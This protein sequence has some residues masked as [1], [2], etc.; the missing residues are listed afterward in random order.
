MK[1]IHTMKFLILAVLLGATFLAVGSTQPGHYDSN[2]EIFS[3]TTEDPYLLA[4]RA[5]VWGYPLVKAARIRMAHTNPDDPHVER[6][7]PSAAGPLNSLNHSRQLFG[8]EFRNGVGVNHDTLYSF[9]WYDLKDEAFVLEAPDFGDRYYTFSIYNADTTSADTIG[10][11]THGSQVPTVLIH[12][13]EYRGDIPEDML[14]VPV[15]TRYL[16]FAGRIL[17]DGSEA[18][19]RK[20]HALQDQIRIRSLS[21]YLQ[22][23]PP[24]DHVPDQIRV[25]ENV[26][27]FPDLEL[28]VQIGNLLRY[29]IPQEGEKE[30]LAS[31]ERIGLTSEGFDPASL[32]AGTREEIGRALA[33][34]MALI[35]KRSLDLGTSVNG[36]SINYQGSRFGDNYLLR[37]AVAKD[38]IYVAAP[39]EAIYPLA[40]VDARGEPLTGD[41][42]YR[43]LFDGDDLPPVDGF[44]SVT[45]YNDEGYLVDNPIDRHAVNERMPGLV[46]KANGDIEIRIQHGKPPGD[47]AVNWLPAPEGSFY[48]MM[49]LYIPH[50][51]ILDGTWVPPTIERLGGQ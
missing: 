49:R 41:A 44:W 6:P 32:D 17:A 42:S 18:D 2:E 21:R 47:E 30:L 46:K 31:F 23:K 7:Q 19:Y 13:P 20:V 48:L 4:L 16:N 27:Q 34:A 33:D 12:G 29:W 10:Q 15:A 9:G 24:S 25:S 51:R 3:R 39:E 5:A 50:E 22:D 37:A 8:H 1:F 36:W 28:F 45:L 26:G 43:I 40:R 14:V 11:R 35:E 38:Q